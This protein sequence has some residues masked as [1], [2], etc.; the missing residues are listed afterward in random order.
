M[1]N[2]YSSVPQ[3]FDQTSGSMQSVSGLKHLFGAGSVS[4]RNPSDS[5]FNVSED[6]EIYMEKKCPADHV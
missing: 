2:L 1:E 3:P 5:Q 4:H 6:L